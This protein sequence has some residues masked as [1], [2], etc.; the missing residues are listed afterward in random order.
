LDAVVV[1]HRR[2]EEVGGEVKGTCLP[3]PRWPATFLFLDSKGTTSHGA[4][5]VEAGK[6][7]EW[8]KLELEEREETEERAG[9]GAALLQ[10]YS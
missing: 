6:V 7:K 2:L 1:S 9:S 10:T 5:E 4:G 8:V 3:V